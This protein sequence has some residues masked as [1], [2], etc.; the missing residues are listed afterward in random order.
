MLADWQAQQHA[1]NLQLLEAMAAR[2]G[3]SGPIGRRGQG[4]A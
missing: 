3:G 1:L 2:S 4:R